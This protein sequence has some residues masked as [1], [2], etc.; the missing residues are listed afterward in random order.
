MPPEID[1]VSNR[2]ESAYLELEELFET[3]DEDCAFE[4]FVCLELEELFQTDDEE[5]DFEGFEIT[6]VNDVFLTDSENED[7]LGFWR[8]DYFSLVFL[9]LSMFFFIISLPLPAVLF[10]PLRLGYLNN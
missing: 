6:N 10:C 7:F 2:A 3:D 4:G 8:H 1:S 5:S 9:F